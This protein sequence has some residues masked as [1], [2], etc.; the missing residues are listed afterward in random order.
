RDKPLESKDDAKFFSAEAWKKVAPAAAK[1]LKEKNLDFVIETMPTPKGDPKKI[2]DMTAKE[3]EKFFKEAAE[4]REKELKIHGVYLMVWKSPSTRYVMVNGEAAA[5]NANFGD[6]L[7]SMLIR[8]FKDGKFDD[9]LQKMID[10]T[11]AEFKLEE[12]K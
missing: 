5:N 11:L 4:E 10:M 2:A 1:I 6:M 12:K 7:K 9:G 8:N 3:R